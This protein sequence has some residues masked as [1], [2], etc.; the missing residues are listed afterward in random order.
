MAS[1][2]PYNAVAERPPKLLA[3]A[4]QL[5]A[6]A[7]IDWAYCDTDSMSFTRPARWSRPRFVTAVNTIRTRLQPLYPFDD[8]GDLLK[9][10]ATN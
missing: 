3:L 6:E 4:E 10:E 9:L 8:G 5:A 7:G 2:S 1:G